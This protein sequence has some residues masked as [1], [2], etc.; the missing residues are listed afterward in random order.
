[1]GSRKERTEI[2]SKLS[3]QGWRY[4]LELG[5]IV[6]LALVSAVTFLM[7]RSK[8]PLYVLRELKNW[9]D[10]RRYDSL[11]V[12]IAEA[13]R[14]DPRLVKAVIWRESRFQSDMQ[15][16]NGERGL[17]QVSEIAARDWAAANGIPH[18]EPA[19]LLDPEINIRVGTWYLSKALQRWNDRDDAVPFALAEYNAGRSRVD[20][21]IRTAMQKGS[22]PVEAETFQASIPFPSTARYVRTILAR[23]DFY[24]R[25]GP[26]RAV[27]GGNG[28]V[29]NA[30]RDPKADSS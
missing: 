17:M 28:N 8:D 20:R 12:R 6:F 19:Q 2:R 16:R 14:V 1:M 3:R 13:Q 23:Y 21:W 22:G 27:D 5:V 29:Q 25:R 10:Y 26:L 4:A 11:I 30:P 18:F 7:V 9:T 15:G 24:K